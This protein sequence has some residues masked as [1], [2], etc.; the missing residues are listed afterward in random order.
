[1]K[2][3]RANLNDAE[4]IWKMQVQA[5]SK[6]YEKYKD[7]ETSPAMEP[8]EKTQM[9]LEQP[10]TYY[11]FIEVEG[12]IV[13]AIRV[14]DKNDGSVA[15]RI[16]PIFIMDEY[17][18]RGYAQATILKVEEVHGSSNWELDTILQEE[19]NCRLYERMGYS[20]SGMIKCVNKSMALISYRKV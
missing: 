14:V 15:K 9:R 18:G 16:S 4:R 10:F 19:G 8:I 2:L 6:L 11:Y 17:R 7:T 5:F 12:I 20:Q 1:M 13:G 3:I